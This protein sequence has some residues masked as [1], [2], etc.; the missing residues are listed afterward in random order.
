MAKPKKFGISESLTKGIQETMQIGLNHA[1]ELHVEFIPMTR[2]EVDPENPREF[3]LSMDDLR[4]GINPADELFDRKKLELESIKSLSHSISE[5]GVINPVIVYRH[6]NQYRLIAGERRTLASILAGKDSIPAR[7]YEQKPNSLNLTL[8]QWI[9]NNER[10]DLTLWEKVINL[11]AIVKAYTQEKNKAEGAITPKEL[12]DLIGCSQ[13]YASNLKLLVEAPEDI[14]TLVERNRL[15]SID[16]GALLARI[17]NTPLRQKATKACLAGASLDELRKYAAD[18]KNIPAAG[19][20][21]KNRVGRP[22]VKVPLGASSHHQVVVFIIQSIAQHPKLKG[23]SELGDLIQELKK[24]EGDPKHVAAVFK[25]IVR[26]LEN[27]QN[28]IG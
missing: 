15:K 13:P 26:F 22:S 3:A 7:I 18:E 20:L 10:E 12:S 25:G 23:I 9:E 14:L 28:V 27:N 1:G 8:L 17:K 11:K 19:A 2:L 6:L 4:N 16:K 5:H 24:G 21:Q